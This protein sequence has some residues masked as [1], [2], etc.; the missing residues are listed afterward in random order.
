[1]PYLGIAGKK[2]EAVA[3]QHAATIYG[4]PLPPQSCCHSEQSEEAAF[5]S[6]SNSRS[7]A[8]LRMTITGFGEGAQKLETGPIS[9]AFE[10]TIDVTPRRFGL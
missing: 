9:A 6:R 8:A 1:M 3:K 5:P 2:L 4:S 10:S 7:F